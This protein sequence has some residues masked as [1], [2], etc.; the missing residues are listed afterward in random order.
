VPGGGHTYSKGLDQ[1]PYNSPQII[2]EAKGAY[3]VDVDGNRFLDWA[4]GNRVMILGHGHEPVLDAVKREIDRG[5]NYTRPGILELELAEYLLDIHPWAEMVKFGKNGS[6]V[7]TAAVKLARAYTGRN[8][9]AVCADHPFFSTHD[10]FIGST[11]IDA[12]IPPSEKNWTVKFRYNDIASIQN[13]FAEH[14]GQ[15]AAIILEPVKNDAPKDDFLR[16]LR[17]L[18]TREGA[19]LIFDEMI[20]AMRFHIQGA[21]HLYGVRPDLATFGKAVS[22]GFSFSFLLGGRDIMRLGGIDHDRA[23]VFLLS[24]TH[25]SESVGLAACRATIDECLRLKTTEHVWS[26]GKRLVEGVRKLA[27]D[28]GVGNHVRVVGFDC[29]PQIL[30]THE[31]GTYWPELHTS[32]HEEVIANG[33]LIPWTSITQAHGEPELLRTFDALNA[34]VNKVRRVLESKAPVESSFTGP[35]VKPVFRKFN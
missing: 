12:G 11:A 29:N 20:A 15:V 27:S 25:A 35:A 3:C 19:V 34:A 28:G 7:T 31:N 9:V 26:L 8:I 18:A 21:H 33:V 5:V 24:Q 30:C 32:F 22:N 2:A 17:E 4:M 1:F 10:W 14:P 6:D 13:I 16:R 23:R